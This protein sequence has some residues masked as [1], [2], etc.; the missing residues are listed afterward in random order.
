MRKSHVVRAG[1]NGV[2]DPDAG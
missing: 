1:G 2:T